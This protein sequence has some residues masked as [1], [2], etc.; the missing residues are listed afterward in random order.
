[1]STGGSITH[2]QFKKYQL[3]HLIDVILDAGGDPDHVAGQVSDLYPTDNVQDYINITEMDLSALTLAKSNN[4]DALTL[5]CVLKRRI[6]S[7]KGFWQNWGD[8]STR[9]WTMLSLDNFEEYLVTDS[10]PNALLQT[11]TAPTTA[12]DVMAITNAISAAIL[13]K[14]PTSHVDLLMKNKG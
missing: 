3:D 10:G 8:N 13:A 11:T 12:T 7:T 6:L 9:D 1:M 14:P 2:A 5:P 4:I